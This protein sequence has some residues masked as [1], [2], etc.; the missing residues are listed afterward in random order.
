MK[1]LLPS[2]L[3]ITALALPVA[4]ETRTEKI[5]TAEQMHAFLEKRPERDEIRWKDEERGALAVRILE[6]TETELRVQKTV[7]R[8]LVSRDVSIAELAGFSFELSSLERRLLREPVAEAVPA[9]RVLWEA[10]A[11]A[12][13]LKGARVGAI[14]IALAKALRMTGGSEAFDEAASLLDEIVDKDPSEHRQ[15]TA[16]LE[17]LTLEMARA[18]AEGSPEKTDEVAWKMTGLEVEPE[19]MLMATAWLADRHF[20][21]LK[22]L[23]SEHPRWELDDEVRPLR[24]R[25]YNLSLDFALYPSLFHGTHVEEASEGLKKAWRVYHH[26]KS[27]ELALHVLE[28]LATLYPASQAAE[29]TAQELARLSAREAA[30]T[31]GEDDGATAEEAET[32]DADDTQA[33]P[34]RP[35]IPKR[36]NL[37]DD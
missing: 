22:N 32:D 28:D 25:L 2:L 3:F 34:K 11:P 4:A 15:K 10:R 21:D 35:Q 26:T 29:E 18:L 37:F 8:E 16:A 31:L 17:L 19:A 7:R 5:P 20:E 6:V 13:E 12:L 23:E 1:L 36:Y 27:P 24:L 9:L 14:G 33:L 30:E